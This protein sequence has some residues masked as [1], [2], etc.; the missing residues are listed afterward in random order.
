MDSC[1][2]ERMADRVSSFEEDHGIVRIDQFG[3]SRERKRVVAKGGMDFPLERDIRASAGSKGNVLSVRITTI[4]NG[5]GNRIS[6][7]TGR[8]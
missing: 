1:A 3:T 4:G 6:G 5:I 7:H 8:F 2:C